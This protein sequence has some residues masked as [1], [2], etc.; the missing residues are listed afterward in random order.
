MLYKNFDDHKTKEYGYLPNT[1][2]NPQVYGKTGGLALPPESRL[3]KKPTT[4][5]M[6]IETG[7][8]HKVIH[9]LLVVVSR[10]KIITAGTSSEIKNLAEVLPL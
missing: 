9:N 2:S 10:I 1:A 5:T 8:Y 7:Q 6:N 4:H 3:V